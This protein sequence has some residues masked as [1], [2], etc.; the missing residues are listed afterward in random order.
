MTIEVLKQQVSFLMTEDV[1]SKAAGLGDQDLVVLVL[2]LSACL[3]LAVSL[4]TGHSL[5]RKA[6][7]SEADD[8]SSAASAAGLLCAMVI[9][10]GVLRRYERAAFLS[11]QGLDGGD[12]ESLDGQADEAGGESQSDFAPISDSSSDWVK[13]AVARRKKAV[14]NVF[15]MLV[16]LVAFLKVAGDRVNNLVDGLLRFFLF[17]GYCVF[18]GQAARVQ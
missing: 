3:F 13:K 14:L 15:A 18:P 6:L 11:W 7:A 10:Y 1:L 12:G 8:G 4:A 9:M 16:L 2:G 5:L 17:P